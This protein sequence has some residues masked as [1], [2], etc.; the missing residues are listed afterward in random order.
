MEKEIIEPVTRIEGHAK[1]SVHLDEDNQVEDARFH[2]TE[3][4]G[5]EK[6]VEGRPFWEMP[7]ITSRICGI[8]PVSHHL[9]AAKAGDMIVDKEIP[10]GAKK[11]RELLHM[12]Q[13]LQSH[14][15]SFFYLSSPDLLFGYDA[16]PSKRNIGGL[17]EE[18]PELAQRGIN[19]RSFGQETI[20]ALGEKKVH[21]EF[22]VP[23]GVT[24]NLDEEKG[25]EL[26]EDSENLAD[27]LLQT[28][29]SLRDV[30]S[31]LD[32]ENK[33]CGV[34]EGG[35]MGLV[36]KSG[37]LEHYDGNLKLIDREGG[38]LEKIN[39]VK[40][41]SIVS[42]RSKDWTYLKFP[43]YSK[44]G[45][46]DGQYR[47]GPLARLNLVEDVGT[48][49]AREEWKR[50]REFSNGNLQEKATYYHYARLVEMLYCLERIQ[51]LLDN[52]LVYN[53]E[54]CST[55]PEPEVGRGVGVIEA[56]RGTLIHDYEVDENGL[57]E[58]ANLIIATTHNNPA[59]NDGIKRV[60]KKFVDGPDIPEGILNK[61]E[62]IVRCYDPCLSCSTHALGKMPINLELV[63]HDGKII[64]ETG[65][66]P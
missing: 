12:G 38:L 54:T 11:L 4:R 61:I 9:G 30:Y 33:D 42:E 14:A 62:G 65:R 43:Y 25:N 46:E 26:K 1:I 40:Y 60:A 6:F 37:G 10:K 15:L 51:E 24:Q 2:V 28:I 44:L 35:Y 66:S 45:F 58:N 16:D 41:D 32:D 53:G 48:D 8:C 5:F 27:Y 22:A 39:P 21:P 20:K 18:N 29:S 50:Y 23:G 56:P 34:F 64:D 19:L 49:L 7:D 47:V 13:I 36:D 17:L 3:F 57:V 52:D 63:S 31:N 59:M 55:P